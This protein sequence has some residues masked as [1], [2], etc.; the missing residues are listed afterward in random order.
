MV[1]IP[2][3]FGARFHAAG[4]EIELTRVRL[5]PTPLDARRAELRVRP[6]EVDP[7][8]H[9]NN[10]VHLDW[11]DEAVAAAGGR[12]AISTFPRRYRLEYVT[13]LLPDAAAAIVTWPSGRAWQVE[14]SGEGGESVAR[15]LLD[16]GPGPD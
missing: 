14:M 10:A 9:L 3:S 6:H 15:G 1:R 11:L 16:S 7:N 8:G 2:E 5:D 13:P 4:S 12:E